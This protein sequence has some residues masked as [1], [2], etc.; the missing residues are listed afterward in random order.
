MT[1]SSPSG[2]DI[3]GTLDSATKDDNRIFAQVAEARAEEY[4]LRGEETPVEPL[5]TP[6]EDVSRGSTEDPKQNAPR[7][8]AK[9][10]VPRTRQE[11]CDMVAATAHSNELPL[12]FFIH[13]LFQESG[14][15]SDVVSRAGAQGIAQFMP[16]T[17]ATVGLH[18][19]FDPLQA[20]AASAR[21][22]GRL[23]RQFG[24]LGLAAAAYNAGPRRIQDWLANKG[25][26]PDETQDYVKAITGRSPE[27]WTGHG[28]GGLTAMLP[29]EAPCQEAAAKFTANLTERRRHL[30]ATEWRRVDAAIPAKNLDRKLPRFSA[31]KTPTIMVAE[32]GDGRRARANSHRDGR[33]RHKG[34][35][36]IQL[37]AASKKGERKI[38]LSRR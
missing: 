12:P 36:A 32:R 1:L 7:P 27:S 33:D 10:V 13:L 16:E 30:R 29:R 4:R 11:I 15:K 6:A 9:N 5:D 34:K 22:L 24:N 28:S 23:V 8:A 38:R 2:S 17:A 19:P 25:K 3:G 21:L 26:L 37:A 35:G 14:F 18:N 20:I 31:E